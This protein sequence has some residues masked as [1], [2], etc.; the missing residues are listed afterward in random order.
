MWVY[1]GLDLLLSRL[2]KAQ[3]SGKFHEQHKMLHKNIT[4]EKASFVTVFLNLASVHIKDIEYVD[5]VQQY[6][7]REN[8][9]ELT[10]QCVLEWPALFLLDL[11]SPRRC[12]LWIGVTPTERRFPLSTAYIVAD[13]LYKQNRKG[14][15][16]ADFDTAIRK[17]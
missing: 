16:R 5:C 6:F 11:Y 14:K 8:N 10:V 13:L 1:Y 15:R 2:S 9:K 3:R 17:I 7:R 12:C 4:D